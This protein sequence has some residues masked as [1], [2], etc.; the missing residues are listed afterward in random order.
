MTWDKHHQTSFP[1]KNVLFIIIKN[2]ISCHSSPCIPV[3]NQTASHLL[4]AN[5]GNVGICRSYTTC[6]YTHPESAWIQGASSLSLVLFLLVA[7]YIIFR[8]SHFF[9]WS[10]SSPFNN[11]K[12]WLQKYRNHVRLKPNGA[13]RQALQTM[14]HLVRHSSNADTSW[15]IVTLQL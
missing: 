7:N 9:S 10:S 4:T 14:S 1:S 15:S 11:S 2:D 5:R 3:N 13:E 12:W 8:T 6:S